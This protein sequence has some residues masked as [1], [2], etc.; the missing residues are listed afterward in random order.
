MGYF[1]NGTE[2][3]MYEA[4]WCNNC[5]H[6]DQCAVWLL[7]MLH[8]YDECNNGNSFLHVLIPRDSNGRNLKCEMF[9]EGK[10]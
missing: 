2:G 9:C 10:G 6:Y 4:E 7:H 5:V 8:N 1:S 3:D